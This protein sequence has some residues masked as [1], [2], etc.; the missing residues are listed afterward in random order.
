MERKSKSPP[1][2]LE[3][4]DKLAKT[5]YPHL[6]GRHIEEAF[7][8]GLITRDGGARVAKGERLELPMLDFSGLDAYLL[9]LTQ[10][11]CP[12]EIS[13]I[14]ESAEWLAV[15][16]PAGVPSHPISLLDRSTVTHWALARY[17]EL[18][19]VFPQAQ[20]TITPHRLDTDTSGVLIVAKT[21][22]AYE[23]WRQAF[24]SKQ[25]IKR[26]LA[27]CWGDPQ[28]ANY[29]IELPICHASGKS[30]RMTTV[31]ERTKIIPPVLPASTSMKVQARRQNGLF[32]ALVECKT[33]VTHQVRVHL[34]AL[35]FPLL[36][37]EKYDPQW[38]SRAVREDHHWLRAVELVRGEITV[39]ADSTEFA[40]KAW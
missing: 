38:E 15:D 16:K 37:D 9:A 10:Q 17:P 19:R 22:A 14:Q 33:G 8:E 24:E 20:P 1:K 18:S 27:W 32:L 28:R 2:V 40:S 21:P 13:I 11:P 25:I 30:G 23:Q 6:T 4:A 31:S 3:R 7:S 34:G 36:G 26:Y 29:E 35:G 39:K 5:R 12:L